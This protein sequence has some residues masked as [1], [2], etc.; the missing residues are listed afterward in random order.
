MM[1]A[2]PG[3]HP[4]TAAGAK[5]T[6]IGTPLLHGRIPAIVDDVITV[7]TPGETVDVVATEYGLAVNPARQDLLQSFKQARLRVVSIQE[8]KARAEQMAGTPKRPEFTDEIIGVVEYR[9]GTVI[10]VVRQ[11]VA[12]AGR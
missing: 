6:I 12:W 10:D 5:L 9:D 3:G 2:G 8:L 7:V 1:R 4:D 11:P